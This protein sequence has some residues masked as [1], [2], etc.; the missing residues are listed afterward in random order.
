MVDFWPILHRKIHKEAEIHCC[1]LANILPHNSKGAE[2][3]VERP[4]KMVVKFWMIF[5]RKVEK[6]PNFGEFVFLLFF[7]LIICKFK[8]Y[9][10]FP[11]DIDI[12]S[13][14]SKGKM[15]YASRLQIND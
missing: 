14:V 12:E 6:G 2:Y 13:F 9:Y 5:Y 10:T 4:E 3:K 1:Q 8:N 11:A 15:H 7:S